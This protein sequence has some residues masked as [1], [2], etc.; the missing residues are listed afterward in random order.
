MA[1]TVLPN[2]RVKFARFACPT[3]K[4]DALLLAAYAR[5]SAGT[6]RRRMRNR[7]IFRWLPVLTVFLSSV[8]LAETA[9]CRI[10]IEDV[11]KGSTY[12]VQQRFTFQKGG[13]AQRKHFETPGNDYACTLAFFELGM[14]TMISCEHK[15]DAG[16][17]F[18]QSDRSAL[19]DISGVNNLA[20]RHGAAFLVITT[21][22]E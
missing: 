5:R 3:R 4:R 19:K 22:C 1:L 16:Q 12:K 20:F 2:K 10:E 13:D 9:T 17:T 7:Q 15:R 21:K 18:F 14:G 11:N 8:S 6:G